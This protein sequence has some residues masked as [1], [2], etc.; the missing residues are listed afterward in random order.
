M[1]SLCKT[2][3]RFRDVKIVVEPKSWDFRDSITN[4]LR[5]QKFNYVD[6][7]AFSDVYICKKRNLA[8]KVTNGDPAGIAWM[9]YCVA[10][11][12]EN[13]LLPQI[14]EIWELPEGYH[15]T[16]ME[17]LKTYRGDSDELCAFENIIGTYRDRLRGRKNASATNNAFFTAKADKG[18]NP[19]AV[20]VAKAI[21]KILNKMGHAN[22]DLHD[23]NVMWRGKQLVVTDP[24][25]AW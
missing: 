5:T 16:F 1:K 24:I 13:P 19:N 23:G 25:C 17:T 22:L 20:K 21:A 3:I 4:Q 10:H 6:S 18:L 11:C 8:I 7:G 14:Y 9:K 15:L 2:V 12:D